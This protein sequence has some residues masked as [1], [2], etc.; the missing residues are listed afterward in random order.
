[1][2]VLYSTFTLRRFGSYAVSRLHAYR[3]RTLLPL[4]PNASWKLCRSATD[5]VKVLVLLT[6]ASRCGSSNVLRNT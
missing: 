3:S 5:N 1:M 4:P 2:L 6:S